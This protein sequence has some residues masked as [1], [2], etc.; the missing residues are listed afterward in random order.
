MLGP[1]R[2]PKI[3]ER[4]AVTARF[5]YALIQVEQELAY[6]IHKIHLSQYLY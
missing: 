3:D 2:N 5:S 6:S 1:L 4:V